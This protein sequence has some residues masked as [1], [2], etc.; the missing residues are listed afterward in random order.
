MGN[1][2]NIDDLLNKSFENFE[3][4][5]SQNLRMQMSKKVTRFN[6]FKFNPGTFNIFYLAPVIIGASIMLVVGINSLNDNTNENITSDINNAKIQND[7]KTISNQEIENEIELSEENLNT[8]N[9]YTETSENTQTNEVVF[10]QST[11]ENTTIYN[12]E[13]PDTNIEEEIIEENITEKTIEESD[14]NTDKDLNQIE[15][16]PIITKSETDIEIVYDTIVSSQTITVTDTVKT[17]V[18]ETVKIKK[19]RKRNK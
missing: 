6:F 19:P 14:S 18:N 10:D 4:P 17:V 13:L 7:N 15:T 1:K 11:Q 12:S 9:E 3:A 2:N 8:Q 5:V 16:K